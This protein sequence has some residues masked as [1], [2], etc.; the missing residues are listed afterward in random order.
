MTC[1][2]TERE[3]EKGGRN[4][5]RRRKGRKEVETEVEGFLERVISKC[6]NYFVSI[7]KSCTHLFKKNG[8]Y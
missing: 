8:L 2:K 4:I 6:R 3:K 1:Y 7:D 5:E